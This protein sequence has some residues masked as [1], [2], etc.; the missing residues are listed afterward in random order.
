ML[1]SISLNSLP[2]RRVAASSCLYCESRHPDAILGT[3]LTI[4][5][6]VISVAAIGL[7]VGPLLTSLACP[8]ML[9]D[10]GPLSMRC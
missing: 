4:G 1:R 6:Q 10:F 3:R 9:A 2:L 8:T 7:E 5:R